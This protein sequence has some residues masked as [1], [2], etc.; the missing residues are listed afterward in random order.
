VPKPIPDDDAAGVS[1]SVFVPEGGRIKDLNVRIPGTS[2]NPGI[3]HGW[4]GDLVIDLIAPDGTTVRLVEHPGGPDNDGDDFAGTTFDDEA[5]TN[6]SAGTA[7][8]AG[9]FRPQR[10]QLSRFDGKS[11]RGT[12]TLRVRD[13]FEGDTGTLEAWR[14]TTQKALCDIDTAPPETALDQAPALRVNETTATFAFSSEDSGAT[15]E[16]RFDATDP[17]DFAPCSSPATF[18]GLSEGPHKLEVRAV[19]GSG[20]HD[21]SPAEHSWTVDTTPP[22]TTLPAGSGPSGFVKETAATFEFSSE[23]NASFQCSLDGEEFVPCVSAHEY[24]GPLD[25]GAHTFA[26]QAIDLA[27]NVD[28]VP[29]TRTWTVDFTDPKPTVTGPAHGSATQDRSPLVSGTAGRG[30][31]DATT[32]LVSV[33]RGPDV[34][35][36]PVG[37]PRTVP[38]G[39]GGLWSVT[40]GDDVS[41]VP[42]EYT[43]EVKQTDQAGNGPGTATSTF[44]VTDDAVAPTVSL[45]TPPSGSTVSDTTPELAGVAGT[46]EGDEGVV[47]VK[48]FAGTLAAG[49]PHQTLIVPR[50]GTSGAWSARPAALAEG[51]WTVRVEQEDSADNVGASAP[52]SFTVDVPDE[53]P[54]PPPPPPASEAPTFALAPAEERLADALAG[55]LTAVAACASACR[56][57]ARLTVSARAARSLGLG[58]KSTALGSGSKRLTGAGTVSVG[59]RLKKRARAALGR[60]DAAT[61]TLRVTVTEGAKTLVLSRTISL[62][63]SAGLRRI[64]SHGLRLWSVCSERCPLSGKLSVSA[65]VARRLGLKARGTAR[66]DVASGRATVPAGSPTRLTLKVHRAAKKALRKARRVRTL[67]EAVAGTAPN[68][69]R[70]A[71]RGLTLRR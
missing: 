21:A 54:P 50:D 11:R 6:I 25:E 38:V 32:V 62:R 17:N 51:T 22:D 37:T 35:G 4:V 48:L 53:P 26:V 56:V 46:A 59:V 34:S 14:L 24:P 68:P 42:D 8:Y 31:G 55:R 28:P 41:L 57:N 9:S 49:L 65:A 69:R 27:N 29:A 60:R 23:A 2:S 1:S 3:D 67:L 15:F 19:D 40:V 20:N 18:A 45:S 64:V 63:R 61:A 30:P 10:D 52:S 39:G 44:T 16:C 36:T 58:R 71:A 66:M 12:W 5:G 47:T 7:P 70:T 43:V 33:F 13:L